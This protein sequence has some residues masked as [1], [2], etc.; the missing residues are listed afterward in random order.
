M[1]CPI[2]G[3]EIQENQKFCSGCGANIKISNI[4]NQI[5]KIFHN[6]IFIAIFITLI[7]LIIGLIGLEFYLNIG[8]KGTYKS[9]IPIEKYQLEK[10]STT[11]LL[12][13][14]I[15]QDKDLT[16]IIP[17]LSQKNTSK[18]FET[19][20]INL[21]NLVENMK[22]D[23][24][25]IKTITTNNEYIYQLNPDTKLINYEVNDWTG[26]WINNEYLNEKYSKYL[27]T[28]WQDYLKLAS[29]DTIDDIEGGYNVDGKELVDEIIA[30]QEF[31]NKYK[32]FILAKKVGDIIHEE[33]EHIIYHEYTFSGDDGSISK[34][35]K[36]GYDEFLNRVD[37]KASEY[38]VVKN[39]YEELKKNCYKPN[40]KFFEILNEYSPNDFYKEQ[41]ENSQEQDVIS[42][43]ESQET[44]KKVR[45]HIYVN[46]DSI[47]DIDLADVKWR[48]GEFKFYKGA[49]DMDATLEFEENKKAIYAIYT[50]II[51]YDDA[52]DFKSYEY[53]DKNN[54][55]ISGF[56]ARAFTSDKYTDYEY[57]KFYY[58]ILFGNK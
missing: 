19:F 8:S 52:M 2:C 45:E 13:M 50:V 55:Y 40:S 54:K 34:E 18:L 42:K 6:K 43:L 30:W 53:F 4:K 14:A 56:E 3:K 46:P 28:E 36:K 15:Q 29:K 11:E 39:C 9:I 31:Q 27:N 26:I 7:V 23:D 17:K 49:E 24:L 33:I 16:E 47:K 21:T 20:Y 57:G 48:Q 37:N 5:I 51:G 10:T 22:V 1:N 38:Q 25:D 58:D 44:W 12:N 35:Y 41:A 32:N